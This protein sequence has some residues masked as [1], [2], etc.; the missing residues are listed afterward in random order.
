MRLDQKSPV[1]RKVIV[2]WYDSETA[3]LITII[4]M[5]AFFW[6][7]ILGIWVA[8]ESETYYTWEYLWVPICV[9]G[10]SCAVIATITIR[11]VKRFAFRFT[12]SD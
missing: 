3:C 5:V 6:F 8:R 1:F 11:L 10:M 12:E 7:G 9:S 4:L 2:P